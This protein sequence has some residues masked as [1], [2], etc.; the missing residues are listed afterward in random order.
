MF[1]PILFYW[2]E[3]LSYNLASAA[4]HEIGHYKSETD[5]R[6]SNPKWQNAIEDM[7][8][9]TGVQVLASNGVGRS[10]SDVD[11]RLMGEHILCPINFYRLD[12][13]ISTQC[14]S[15]RRIVNLTR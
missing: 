1:Q 10:G 7:H 9:V 8:D 15:E 6:A 14:F 3:F 2:Q 4:F 12:Q 11:F 13:E 5:N